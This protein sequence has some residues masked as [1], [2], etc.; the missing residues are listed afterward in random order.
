M[1]TG[2]RLFGIH[3]PFILTIVGVI[4]TYF[5]VRDPIRSD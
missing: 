3:R 5:V 2:G 4:V 1:L